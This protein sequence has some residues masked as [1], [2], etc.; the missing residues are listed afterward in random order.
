MTTP[1]DR[2]V[3]AQALETGFTEE[4]ILGWRVKVNAAFRA[5]NP[6]TIAAALALLQR[7]LAAIVA[8]LPPQRLTPLQAT[9][10]WLDERV[11]EGAAAAKAPTFHPDR[12]WLSAH[13][14]N[15]DMAGGIELPNAQ[16]FIDS[17]SWEP[18][19]IMHELAHVYHL[20]VL[21]ENNEAIRGAFEHARDAGLY[22]NVKRY[23]GSIVPKAY[24]L[25]N[26]R[27]YFAELTE[28]YFGRNDYFQFT[29]DELAQ[30]DPTGFAMIRKMWEGR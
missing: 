23:D 2:E 24:A 18:W 21:G 22:G 1:R 11:H 25:E 20:R 19:A 14:L 30:Y 6:D 15:P 9:V 16:D 13:G 27:E 26:E 4:T 28:A 10:F 5:S 3:L 7:E 17:Y 29:R 12:G 8:A